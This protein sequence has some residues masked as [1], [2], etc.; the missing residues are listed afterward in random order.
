[1][2]EVVGGVFF[3]LIAMVFVGPGQELG[4]ALT[5]VPNR[6]LAYTINISGSLVG[7]VLLGLMSWLE[8][9]PVV[10]FTLA[11]AGL[12]YFLWPRGIDSPPLSRC[13]AAA[14]PLLLVIGAV[15]IHAGAYVWPVGQHVEFMRGA[16][17]D[18]AGVGVDR[19]ELQ[20]QAGEDARIRVVHRLVG[21]AQA[22]GAEV[23]AV[24]VLHQELARAHHAEARAD[25]VAELDLDL[26]EVDRQLA[27]TAQLAACDVGDD[28]LVRRPIHVGTLVPVL[29]TQQLGP[30]VVGL[31]KIQLGA[32]DQ[33]RVRVEDDRDQSRARAVV[34]A[35]EH[36]LARKWRQLHGA[37]LRREGPSGGGE[38]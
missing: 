26:V 25:L 33:I 20:A 4:R 30:E 3:L 31:P 9:S 12:L 38:A 10:W 36:G 34:A 19:A 11:A 14:A 24:G 7:I 5:R 37:P 8:M 15:S 16:A 35:D 17:A 27:V 13:V 21:L 18:G 29:E 2:I 22:L 32:H 6:V 1:M 28:F 23:E